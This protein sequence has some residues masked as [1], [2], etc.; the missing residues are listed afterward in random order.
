MKLTKKY[1]EDVG[2]SSISNPF[3]SIFSEKLKQY[4]KL[5]S[6]IDFNKQQ[7]IWGIQLQC[8]NNINRNYNLTNAET[9]RLILRF[10][11]SSLV[12]HCASAISRLSN[13]FNGIFA[14]NENTK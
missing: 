2:Y 4:S 7:K 8:K 3:I 13:G 9:S 11:I 14:S 12:N 10:F 1:K 6:N 5:T